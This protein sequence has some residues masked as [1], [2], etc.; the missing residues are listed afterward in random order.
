[1]QLHEIISLNIGSYIQITRLPLPHPTY[2]MWLP[3]DC[4]LLHEWTISY[5]RDR[6]WRSFS[7]WSNGIQLLPGREEASADF[8]FTTRVLQSR[9]MSS[10]YTVC[11]RC[12][13]QC[14]HTFTSSPH[15]HAFTQSP[16]SD[17]ILG[18]PRRRS[19]NWCLRPPSPSLCGG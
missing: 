13:C 2:K 5:R 8:P 3:I 9:L 6:C 7:C 16:H 17:A 11:T 15:I 12:E 19:S 14:F 10:S 18:I 1:M 4:W